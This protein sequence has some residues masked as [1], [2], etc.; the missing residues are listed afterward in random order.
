MSDHELNLLTQRLI[1]NV[2]T[3]IVGK[4]TAVELSVATLL[5]GGH[6]LIE[7]IPGVGKTMLARALAG[8]IGGQFK[9]IQFTPDLL[10]ADITGVSI[11][12]Q[13]ERAF[14]FVHGP[15]FANVVLADEINR[16]TP[17]SQSALLEAMEEFQ[18]TADGETRHLPRPFFVI[19]TE[20]P[21]EYEGT[22]SLPEAQLDRFMLSVH[23][24]YPSED[25]ERAIVASTTSEWSPQVEKVM[26]GEEALRLQKVVRRVPVS[27][28]ALD[29]AVR[30]ARA[31]RPGDPAAPGFI[32]N[33]VTWGAGPRAS[34]AM[35]LGAKARALMDGR[36]AAS[37]EDVAALALPVLRHRVIPSF[38]AEADGI[39]SADIVQRLLDTVPREK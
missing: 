6:M 13:D 12:N 4:R 39:S 20:N 21:I 11:Y 10:P 32:G 5:S 24:D 16:A 31:T 8:S 26:S 1:E 9:R 7:D 33:W 34:Q 37:R 38:A 3:V 27:Q 25:E 36:Y 14:E 29:Y 15:I 35:I 23:L 22:F 30:L 18:V 17:K 28:D 2:E 19:A